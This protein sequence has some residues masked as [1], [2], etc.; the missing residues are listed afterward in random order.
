MVQVQGKMDEGGGQDNGIGREVVASVAGLMV[1][2]G[3]LVVVAVVTVGL[4]VAVVVGF[5]VGKIVGVFGCKVVVWIASSQLVILGGYK[6]VK[7][8]PLEQAPS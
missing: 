2:E 6:F 3:S 4:L 7:F 1:V 8:V 5:F